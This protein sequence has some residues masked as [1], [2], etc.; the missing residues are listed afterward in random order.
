MEIRF[1]CVTGHRK[2][3]SNKIDYVKKE[4]QREVLLAIEDGFTHFM[5]G[6][7]EGVDLHFASIIAELKK[8]NPALYLAAAILLTAIG[9]NQKTSC[10]LS[11]WANAMR[12]DVAA[13]NTIP[14]SL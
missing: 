13:R 8:E 2:V 1:C 10:S 14:A 5:S 9:S 3:P 6:F 4:L 11:C 7:A 12:S